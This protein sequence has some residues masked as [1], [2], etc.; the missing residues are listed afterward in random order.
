MTYEL[1]EVKRRRLRQS[2]W[3]ACGIDLDTMS[4]TDAAKRLAEIFSTDSNH[5]QVYDI[6]MEAVPLI[7]NGDLYQDLIKK[8]LQQ[9]A[10]V[11]RNH[12]TV[13]RAMASADLSVDQFSIISQ[14]VGKTWDS[15]SSSWTSRYINGAELPPP[16][17][18][19]STAVK[20]WGAASK[21]VSHKFV[22]YE[23]DTVGYSRLITDALSDFFRWPF[24]R[25]LYDAAESHRMEKRP[26]MLCLNLD[27]FPAQEDLHL[28]L[29]SMT[30]LNVGPISKSPLLRFP[31]GIA[32]CPDKE[33][34]AYA[35]IF[36][37]NITIINESRRTGKITIPLEKGEDGRRPLLTVPV[38]VLYPLE[39]YCITLLAVATDNVFLID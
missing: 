6:L 8:I 19:R 17:F 32:T 30:V 23:G 1:N 5:T 4:T 10:S 15:A 28:T 29:M 16:L 3:E 14:I 38:S 35:E 9:V 22:A 36:K 11:T 7:Q 39:I 20:A 25:K 27:G 37:D 18:G 13:V 21:K 33:R 2:L 24:T 34:D 12:E 31:L 26:L